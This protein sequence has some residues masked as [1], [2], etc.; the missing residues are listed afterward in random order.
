[1]DQILYG[2]TMGIWEA[3][4]MHFLVR[5]NLIKYVENII[6]PK[7]ETNMKDKD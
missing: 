6:K 2:S 3:F 4:T 7:N 1:L 5:D